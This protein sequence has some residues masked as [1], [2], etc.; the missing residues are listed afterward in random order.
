MNDPYSDPG[1]FELATVG[2][3]EWGDGWYSFNLTAVWRRQDGQLV[4]AD[5]AGCSCPSPF[6]D[7]KAEDLTPVTAA[8]LQAHLE[9]RNKDGCSEDRSAQIVEL[10]ALVVA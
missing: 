5:D 4:M 8:E 3:I 2:E 1:K 7:I 10:M 6:E 9:A